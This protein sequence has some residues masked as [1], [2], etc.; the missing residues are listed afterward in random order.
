MK[1]F[2]ARLL[3]AFQAF[4]K[5]IK[6]DFISFETRIRDLEYLAQ[7]DAKS[8]LALILQVLMRFEHRADLTW[9][10][11]HTAYIDIVAYAAKGMEA[12]IA[13]ISH[14]ATSAVNNATGPLNDRIYQLEQELKKL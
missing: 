6:G 5:A 12:N 4:W 3:L 2:Y 10:D 8:E 13:T 14:A 1:E 7:D 11:L 9:Q